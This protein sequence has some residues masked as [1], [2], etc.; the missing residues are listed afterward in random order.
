[1][2]GA[3]MK[4]FNKEK[5]KDASTLA[6]LIEAKDTKIAH[7]KEQLTGMNA[8]ISKHRVEKASQS[9]RIKFLEKSLAA[10]HE[11]DDSK[12]IKKGAVLGI[13]ED[14]RGSVM[15][16]D[17]FNQVYNKIRDAYVEILNIGEKK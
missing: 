14:L 9:I 12:E 13:L 10:M 6:A 4:L 17:T 2:Y 5:S 15:P 8:V 1:M 7:Q 3:G 11:S 16:D